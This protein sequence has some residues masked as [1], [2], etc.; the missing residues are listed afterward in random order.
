M[1]LKASNTC[2]QN[3]KL[4][5]S[6][7]TTF[8]GANHVKGK[9][10]KGYII[11]SNE[12]CLASLFST[13]C[14][15]SCSVPS[16]MLASVS[17]KDTDA[18][19][20]EGQKTKVED[21]AIQSLS[22]PMASSIRDKNDDCCDLPI[23][24][25]ENQVAISQI[26]SRMLE[27]MADSFLLLTSARLRAFVN[28]LARHGINLSSCPAL[29][30]SERQEGVFAVDRKLE[31]LLAVGSGLSVKNMVINYHPVSHSTDENSC[32]PIVMETIMDISIPKLCG[33][34]QIVTV[35]ISVMG[36]L[37]GKFE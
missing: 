23:H 31:A 12:G 35:T 2:H 28:I 13:D 25:S 26:P 20:H 15:V 32:V 10:K 21:H 24:R 30:E 11:H 27:H 17:S 16:L 19:F 29:T 14:D 18:H 1:E 34:H 37:S 6:R 9:N 8:L 22:R 5:L 7:F 33:T 36:S 4:L 3:Q